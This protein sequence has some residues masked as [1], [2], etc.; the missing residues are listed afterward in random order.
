M[1][2][3]DHGIAL[4][5]DHDSTAVDALD[6]LAGSR[7]DMPQA[8]LLFDLLAGPAELALLEDDQQVAAEADSLPLLFCQPLFD[9]PRLALGQT[10][11]DV[12]PEPAGKLLRLIAGDL[13]VQPCR[14]VMGSELFEWPDGQR[15]DADRQASALLPFIAFGICQ[16]V[17][18]DDPTA[19][20]LS[21]G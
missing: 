16:M 14:A 2:L 4:V 13:A 10:L 17:L 21:F 5:P 8:R 7:R 3:L 9:E 15:L 12:R 18:A 20:G 1:R 11:P 19:V 6:H